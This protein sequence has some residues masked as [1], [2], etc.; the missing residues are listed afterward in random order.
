MNSYEQAKT[1]LNHSFIYSSYTEPGVPYLVSVAAINVAGTGAPVSILSFT[2]EKGM[3][4]PNT[5]VK[6]ISYVGQ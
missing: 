6:N 1:V 3:T 2:E 5:M 4:N